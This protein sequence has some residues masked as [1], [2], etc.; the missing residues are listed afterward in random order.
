MISNGYLESATW[1]SIP[2]ASGMDVL[3]LPAS[4]KTIET[5]AFVNVSCQE[6]IIPEG[7]TTI[8]E[9]AFRGCSDLLYV[10]IP[11][12]VQSYPANAFDGCNAGL[13]IDYVGK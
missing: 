11:S 10:K 8:G 5:E 12:S 7:C 6:I 9:Y 3:R 1:R 13:V 4:L 2:V